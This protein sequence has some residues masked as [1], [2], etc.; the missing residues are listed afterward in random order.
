MVHGKLRDAAELAAMGAAA[1]AVRPKT[2]AP[3]LDEDEYTGE[4]PDEVKLLA[5]QFAGPP[6]G[7]I[8]KILANKFRPMNL[9]KLRH[10]RGCDDMYRDQISIEEGTLKMRKVTGSY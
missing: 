8:A 3:T 6:Q 2:S 4:I 10:T 9:H 7:E 5:S 1:I